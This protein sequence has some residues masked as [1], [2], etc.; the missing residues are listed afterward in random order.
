[1]KYVRNEVNTVSKWGEFPSE[2]DLGDAIT[3]SLLIIDKPEGPS[4]HQV[5]A[6]VKKIFDEKA[7]HS[8]TLDP[9][10]TGVLPCGI[11]H[12]VRIL[13]LLHSVPKEYIAAMK[14]HGNVDRKEV[15]E[16]LEEFTGE[17]YQTPPVRS[18]VKRERRSRVIYDIELLDSKKRE[19]LMK[20]RC[21]SG[22]Y[23]RTLCN[24]IGKAMGPGGHMMELRRT[25][26]GGFR[27][28]DSVY[29]QDVKDAFEYHKKG[30]DERLKD[31][32]LPYERALDIFPKIRVKDTAAGSILNG[33]DLAAPG[34]LKM[35][36]FSEGDEVAI[37]SAK[38]EGLAVGEALVKA[39]NI[40]EK[41]KGLV[42][43]TERVF[44]PSGEYPKAW[45]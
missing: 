43:K 26:A 23:I 16:L 24:D 29:L 9:N 6:W 3:R 5:S 17:I 22:T 12:S 11:G 14:F 37:V 36:T 15:E 35:D 28:K 31:I 45:K 1:M 18:G 8:G 38:G 2:R 41:E 13:D 39:E 10:V 4:S 42:V 32:L 44:S 21:E 27:E 25:E 33:A 7:A 34:I 40:M 19:Y 30:K 20:V